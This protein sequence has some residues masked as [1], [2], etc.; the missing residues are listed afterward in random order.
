M[1]REKRLI[2]AFNLLNKEVN[3]VVKDNTELSKILEDKLTPAV[4]Q[5]MEADVDVDLKNDLIRSYR[6]FMEKYLQSQP[7]LMEMVKVSTAIKEDTNTEY[8]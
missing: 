4:N 6:D 1:S 2:E 5:I 8:L 7:N 3:K